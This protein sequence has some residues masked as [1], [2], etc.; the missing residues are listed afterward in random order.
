[1]KYRII[2]LIWII[3]LFVSAQQTYPFDPVNQIFD[4]DILSVKITNQDAQFGLP[5]ITLNSNE[6]FKLVF[7]DLEQYDRYL[8][9]TLIHCTHDWQFSELNPIEYL[10]GFMEDE[11][12][13]Y[14]FSFNT[15]QHYTHYELIF[16]TDLLRITKSGNYLLVVYDT[17]INHP[18]LTRRVMVM[19]PSTVGISARV[20]PATDVTYKETKQ[21][22]DFIV[23]SGN[24]IV[25]NP[26]LYLHATIIQ[27]GRWD[28][29]IMGLTYRSLKPGE[30]SFQYENLNK[31]LFSGG[32]EFR[33]FDIRTLRNLSDR[34]VSINF[35][36]RINQ[37]YVMEDVARPLG[38]YETD[39]TLQGACYWKNN[40]FRGENTEDYVL[41]HF[42]LKS[43]YD[44]SKGDV[45][46]FGELTDWNLDS[47]AK[48]TYNPNTRYWETSLYLKQGFYNYQYVYVPKGST[49]IDETYIE[50]SHWQT[51]NSYTVLIY[52]REEGTSYDKLIGTTTINLQQ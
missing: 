23:Y 24:Y 39:P 43:D 38:A 1:M 48:L 37:A 3:P 7:D 26:A 31:T 51:Q 47:D 15:I 19:E 11:V 46:V 41:T 29:A 27:N 35:K 5:I 12:V 25:R 49:V 45:Y 18:V 36:D 33:R 9:Y 14:T 16:P 22:V 4:Q 34:I 17:D 30:F 6:K 32:S 52:L 44:L 50:G 28:N 40:D 13:N 21:Q 8:K 20:E 2:L 10:D 42:S